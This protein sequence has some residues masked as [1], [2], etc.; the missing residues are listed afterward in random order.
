MAQTFR[1]V[2]CQ[3]FRFI[4]LLFYLLTGIMKTIQTCRIRRLCFITRYYLKFF[5]LPKRDQQLIACSLFERKGLTHEEK[6]TWKWLKAPFDWK[7]LKILTFG[8]RPFSEIIFCLFVKTDSL[9][10]YKKTHSASN[11]VRLKKNLNY[12]LKFKEQFLKINS[13]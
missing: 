1:R 6:H 8:C 7:K 9:K 3:R 12:N 11:A 5:I 13:Q 10:L 4:V 2:F